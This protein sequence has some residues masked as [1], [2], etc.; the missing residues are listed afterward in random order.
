MLKFYNIST[1]LLATTLS[2]NALADCTPPFLTDAE[3]RN[4]LPDHIACVSNGAGGWENQEEHIGSAG[5][6]SGNLYDYKEGNLPTS[7]D[8]REQLGTWSISGNQIHY[9]YSG[10][11]SFS[12]E[13]HTNGGDSYTFCGPATVNATIKVNNGNGC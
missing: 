13:L 8:K 10:G 2:N 11:D 3:L 4:T 12:F 9:S 7:I 1:I 6:S 5:D